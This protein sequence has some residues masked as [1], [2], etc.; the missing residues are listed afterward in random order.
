MTYG[1]AAT[2]A[3]TKAKQLDP[4]NP[5]V[6]LLEGQDKF[7]TPAEFGGSKEEGKKLFEQAKS[8]MEAFTPESSI[9]SA[10]GKTQLEY[11][12]SQG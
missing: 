11:F 10:W 7:Y 8:K 12:L 2:Q 1:P 4:D 5:R 3:L 9:H 6:Y